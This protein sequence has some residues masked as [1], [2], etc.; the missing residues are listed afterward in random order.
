MNVRELLAKGICPNCHSS[1]LKLDT[2]TAYISCP[3][4]GIHGN[5]SMMRWC[6]RVPVYKPYL[7]GTFLSEG[8]QMYQ[9]GERFYT[10][11]GYAPG[12]GRYLTE[13]WCNV[14]REF[15]PPK[16]VDRAVRQSKAK[17]A[18]AMSEVSA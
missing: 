14:C 11:A 7:P 16:P 1:A 8:E 10:F 2:V 3:T 6:E 17:S 4:C 15:A 9:S 18:R 13:E 5:P 12:C